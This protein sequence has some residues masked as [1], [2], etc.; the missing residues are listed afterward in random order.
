MQIGCFSTVSMMP[1]NA[2]D[3]DESCGEVGEETA[4]IRLIV[5]C[6]QGAPQN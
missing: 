1:A 6:K 4:G 5:V 3:I 2:H